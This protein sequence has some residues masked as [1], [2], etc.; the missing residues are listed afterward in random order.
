MKQTLA[1]LTIGVVP[2][3]EILPLLTDHI[4]EEQIKTFSLLGNLSYDEVM[5]E[6]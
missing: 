4:S 5:E 2:V 3:S 6:F 1:I